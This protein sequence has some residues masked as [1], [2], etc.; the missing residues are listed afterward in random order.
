MPTTVSSRP[1]PRPC[2][3]GVYS[4]DIDLPPQP[5]M[6][7]VHLRPVES[8]QP[9]GVVVESEEQALGVEPRLTPSFVQ[10]GLLPAALFGMPG[11]GSVVDPQQLGVVGLAS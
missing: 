3:A 9:A 1:R 7:G 8:E 10:I 4:D 5:G 2:A 6:V 11:E